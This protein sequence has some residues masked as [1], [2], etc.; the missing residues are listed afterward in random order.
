[1]E[2]IF[3]AF[4]VAIPLVLIWHELQEIRKKM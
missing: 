2:G 3:A 4:V 1:M